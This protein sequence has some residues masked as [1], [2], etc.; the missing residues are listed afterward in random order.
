MPTFT[1]ALPATFNL[2][3]GRITDTQRDILV[4]EVRAMSD[5]TTGRADVHDV[6]RPEYV[7]VHRAI[8]DILVDLGNTVAGAVRASPETMAWLQR[9]VTELL[10]TRAAALAS[11]PA[12]NDPDPMRRLEAKM[13]AGLSI[14]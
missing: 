14:L 11:P 9:S 12:E 5:Y 10:A 3:T 4:L 8:E 6:S 7:H 2:R 13:R 1:L